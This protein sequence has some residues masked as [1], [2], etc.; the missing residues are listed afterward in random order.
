MS[1][2]RDL[3]TVET[4]KGDEQGVLRSPGRKP[5]RW[6]P[7]TIIENTVRSMASLFKGDPGGEGPKGDKGEA[8]KAGAMG[9]QGLQGQTGPQ[10]AVGP[11]GPDRIR[12]S[13]TVTT[14]ADGT[15]TIQNVPASATVLIISPRTDGAIQRSVTRSGTSV[16]ISFRVLQT[17]L[18][19]GLLTTLF[20][21]N[22][23]VTFDFVALDPT[24]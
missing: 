21:A 12:F 6:V 23:A 10:G 2:L 18:L 24:A 8:G 7:K 1:N 17:G 9:A 22:A 20:A 13:R 5:V 15:V 16:T 11:T 14:A 3:E 4:L 19:S